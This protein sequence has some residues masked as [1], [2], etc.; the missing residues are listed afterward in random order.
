MRTLPLLFVLTAACPAARPLPAR[1]VPPC[2]ELAVLGR[3]RP[4]AM[5][6]DAAGGL[7]VAG[8]FEG[9]MRVLNAALDSAGTPQAF[10]LQMN[11]DASVRW[12]RRFGDAAEDRAAAVAFAPGGDV[13]VATASH[14]RCIVLRLAANDGR[15]IWTQGFDA[16]TSSCSA[17]AFDASGA[18]WVA[19]SFSGNLFGLAPAKGTRDAFVARLDGTSG[20]VNLVR[21]FGGDGEAWVSAL[22]IG[23]GGSVVAG[24]GF[25]GRTD[26]SEFD[27]GSGAVKPAGGSDALLLALQP[28]GKVRWSIQF[29]DRLRD[30][31]SSLATG[32]DGSIFAAGSWGWT[33]PG[34]GHHAY[35]S[36][37]VAKVDGDGRGQ[38]I[39]IL[40][41]G[42]APGGGPMPHLP[43]DEKGRLW[44]ATPAPATAAIALSALSPLD[45]APLGS[46]TWPGSRQSAAIDSAR[47]PGGVALT[48]VA[49]GELEICGKAVGSAGEQTAFIA[50]LRDL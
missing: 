21:S 37:F 39:R 6:S 48:G 46:R 10:L 34:G 32:P 28:E 24:G 12:L 22:S 38:W 7:A 1:A 29:G 31:V 30:S 18:A 36:T 15:T 5:A 40:D 14:G 8:T 11:P 45:G 49:E 47:I 4:L 23:A 19:G 35:G 17:A 26:E 41:P 20:T 25:S 42:W 33:N 13:L 27:F 50:W 2:E 16:A 44:V 43:Q 3:A 9:S